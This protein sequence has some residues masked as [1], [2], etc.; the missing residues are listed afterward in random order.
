M[1]APLG[2]D[3]LRD[4]SGVLRFGQ[5][6]NAVFN[7]V[8]GLGAQGDDYYETRVGDAPHVTVHQIQV[9]LDV[10]VEALEREDRGAGAVSVFTEGLCTRIR[11]RATASGTGDQYLRVRVHLRDASRELFSQ[12][13]TTNDGFFVPSGGH[14]ELTEFRLNEKRS[15]PARVV[16]LARAG[17]FRLVNVHYFLI[18][19]LQ[20]QLVEQHAP[21]HK[22]RRLEADLWRHYLVGEAP[23]E[24]ATRFERVAARMV[25]YHW[26]KL[27]SES[28]G[29]SDTVKDYI[30]FASFRSSRSHLTFYAAA[31]VLLGGMGSA[32]AALLGAIFDG[33]LGWLGTATGGYDGTTAHPS[34]ANFAVFVVLGFLVVLLA[35]FAS[36][37][38]SRVRV[39]QRETRGRDHR[40]RGRP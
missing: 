28:A 18:R 33:G 1:P 16:E 26:R 36:A 4:L 29:G 14:L 7:D 30:A 32:L 21:F 22:I 25:I 3:Q 12:E 39:R 20:Y 6:L 27:A 8:I 2:E 11:D 9:G 19:D 23:S 5:T 10:R 34:W 38:W 40:G 37:V 35:L 24:A 17:S 31:V 15:Y 13:V